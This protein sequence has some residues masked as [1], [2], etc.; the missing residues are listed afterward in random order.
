VGKKDEVGIPRNRL[1]FIKRLLHRINEG[2]GRVH[3]RAAQDAT[4]C[5]ADL[6]ILKMV[7]VTF[8]CYQSYRIDRAAKGIA[9][10]RTK[11]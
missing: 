10:K 7:S 3:A 8:G 1:T 4:V 9:P 11:G 5:V 2:S 6:L